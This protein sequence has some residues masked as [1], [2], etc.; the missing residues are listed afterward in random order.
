MASAIRDAAGDPRELRETFDMYAH[1]VRL[2]AEAL[3]PAVREAMEQ[4][5]SALLASILGSPSP[6]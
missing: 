2:Q 1:P 4:R 6:A 5:V 3:S